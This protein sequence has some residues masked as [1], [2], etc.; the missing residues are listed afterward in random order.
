MKARQF[1]SEPCKMDRLPKG[2]SNRPPWAI[3]IV[4]Y[5]WTGSGTMS[6]HSGSVPRLQ[7]TLSDSDCR[8]ISSGR[9]HLFLVKIQPFLEELQTV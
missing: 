7:P 2:D 1:S 5:W 8:S 4:Q 9:R 3:A 6:I